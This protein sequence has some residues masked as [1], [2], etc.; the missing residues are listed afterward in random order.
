MVWLLFTFKSFN[1]ELT[2]YVPTHNDMKASFDE[3]L[4]ELLKFT[5]IDEDDHEQIKREIKLNGYIIK[6]KL[7]QL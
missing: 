7:D 5:D 3:E 6:S 2:L 4:E 1:F